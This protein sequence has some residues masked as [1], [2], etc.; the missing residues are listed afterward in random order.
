[1]S[2]HYVPPGQLVALRQ[3]LSLTLVDNEDVRELK[4]WV[5]GQ[6]PQLIPDEVVQDGETVAVLRCP[7]CNVEHATGADDG[8]GI[9]VVDL[10]LRSST[11]FYDAAEQQIHGY[12]SDDYSFDT[13]CYE[14]E[15]CGK[16][17]RLPPGIGEEGDG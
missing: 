5:F 2:W 15:S 9:A 12:Y 1:M 6:V 7:H 8:D 14:C 4:Q 11:F 3:I 10:A 17:V 13:Y 16:E